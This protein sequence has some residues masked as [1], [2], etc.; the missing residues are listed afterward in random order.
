MKTNATVHESAYAA[1]EIATA[2]NA[3]ITG[4]YFAAAQGH[5]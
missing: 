3:T 5:G 1:A 2:G 4:L